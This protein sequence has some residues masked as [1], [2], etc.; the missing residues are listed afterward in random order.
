M[1][2]FHGKTLLCLGLSYNKGASLIRTRF[3]FDKSSVHR[4]L[5]DW[6]EE[7]DKAFAQHGVAFHYV[8]MNT[9]KFRASINT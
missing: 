8:S 2:G 5:I 7:I 6:L 1:F 4:C 3:L 9:A